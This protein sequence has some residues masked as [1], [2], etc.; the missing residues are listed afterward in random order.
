[1]R[2][3]SHHVLFLDGGRVAQV[4]PPSEI[5]DRPENERLKSFLGRFHAAFGRAA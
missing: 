3:V 5:F 1:V 2:E 4:G